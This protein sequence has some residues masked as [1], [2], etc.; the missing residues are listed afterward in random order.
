M[1]KIING[2]IYDTTKADEIVK[3]STFSFFLAKEERTEILYKTKKWEYFLYSYIINAVSRE[4]NWR[5]WE[6]IKS[7]NLVQ[8]L[9]WYEKKQND[10]LEDEKKKF[11]KEFSKFFVEA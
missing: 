9:D 3:T 4:E 6:N 5:L 7:I 8:I 11:L 10:F 1:E 2:K